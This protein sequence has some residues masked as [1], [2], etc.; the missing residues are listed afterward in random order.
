MKKIA[1]ITTRYWYIF[2]ILVLITVGGSGYLLTQL[3]MDNDLVSFFPKS[4]PAVKVFTETGE[5]FGSSYLNMITVKTDN[6]FTHKNLSLIKK[7]SEELEKLDGVDQI[8]SITNILDVKKISGG[9]EVGKL[10]DKGIIPKDKEKLEKLRTY[11]LSKEMYRDSIINKS[12]KTAVIIQRIN[13]DADKE[14]LSEKTEILA[15]NLIK[16]N[17]GVEVFFGGMPFAMFYAN[18]IVEHDLLLLTPLVAFLI[19]FVLFVSFRSFRGVIL[20]LLTVMISTLIAI[21]LMSLFDIPLTMLS[22][23][24]PVV[25]LSTGTAYVIHLINADRE[26]TIAGASSVLDRLNKA[27]G[28]VGVA[29]LLS[30][31]TTVIGFVSLVTADL[32]PIKEFGIFVAVGILVAL[33]LT[34]FLVPSLLKI[35]PAKTKILKKLKNKN[36]ISENHKETIIDKFLV[37][38]A[39]FTFSKPWTIVIIASVIIILSIISLPN[40]KQE[41]NYFKYF[42]KDNPV[43]LG[44]D[45]LE[46]EFGGALPIVIDF[47]ADNI[48]HPA[49]LR[50]LQRTE[51]KLKAMEHI[52]NPQSVTSLIMEMNEIMNGRRITPDT[53]KGVENLWIFIDGKKELKQM[54]G[55]DKKEAIIQ[56]MLNQ[57]DTPT[58]VKVSKAVRELVDNIPLKWGSI[59]R[60]DL[61]DEKRVKILTDIQ[62]K[63]AIS[64]IENDLSFIGISIKDK[65]EFKNVLMGIILAPEPQFEI[66]KKTVEKFTKSYIT[67]ENAEVEIT[68]IDS[69]KE[70]IASMYSMNSWDAKTIKDIIKSIVSKEIIEEDPEI[71][72]DFSKSLNDIWNHS[73]K[74]ARVIAMLNLLNNHISKSNNLLNGIVYERLKGDFWQLVED[75]IWLSEKD[76]K[77]ITG[78]APEKTFDIYID[79]TGITKILAQVQTRLLS[80]QIQSLAIAIFLVLLLLI[81]QLRSFLG[82]FL[83]I[84][85][86]LFTIIFNFGLMSLF[87]VPLDNAT[88]MIASIAIGIGID[89]TIHIISRFKKEY[90]IDNNMQR[91][92]SITI[93]TSGRAVLINTFSVMLG[94]LVLIFSE[95]EPLRRFGYLTAL[96]MFISAGSALT[97]FPAAVLVTKAS[98]MT[99]LKKNDIKKN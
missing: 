51:K 95:L 63:S 71:I 64:D 76:Y 34:F 13:P 49:F 98:F 26:V 43:R 78:V 90:L 37:K 83:A 2:L 25:L 96:T 60:K 69:T 79:D 38:T 9:L 24:I 87:G 72:E 61:K 11:T 92:L 55:E 23:M 22:S 32:N 94:F 66:W 82:G 40:L 77:S 89:Y 7:I 6:V 12:G 62:I 17:N 8:I 52:R 36:I 46:K 91:A 30:G 50:L 45:L 10:I 20:P 81:T 39:D 44:V 88:M 35:W 86:V 33:F 14:G 84:I 21:G 59:E 75:K 16:N 5:K 48:K 58:I 42:S 53:V 97:V 57:S 56:V 47:K 73:K 19:I 93:T 29:I 85:P 80:S 15:K 65:T 4:D 54:V 74:E 41:V 70:L 28:K 27:F 31:L 18:K 67:S 68:N 1:E 99:K 3:K